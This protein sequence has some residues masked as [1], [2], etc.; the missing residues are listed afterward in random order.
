MPRN[1]KLL[2]AIVLS[3]CSLLAVRTYTQTQLPEGP[4]KAI[5][6]SV[7]TQCHDL[8]QAVSTGRTRDHWDVVVQK[9]IDYGA[10]LPTNQMSVVLD[11][12]A[13]S[14]PESVQA[15][16]AATGNRA[17]G[18]NAEFRVETVATGLAYPWSVAFLPNGDMLVTER[19]AARLRII[20]QGVLDPKPLKGLPPIY[21]GSPLSGL[22]DIVLHPRFAENGYLYLSYSKP[23]PDLTPGTPPL[24]ASIPASAKPGK[25]K[26]KTDALLRAR[27]DGKGLT[28]IREIFVDNNVMDDSIS[29]TS[30]LRLVFGSDGMLYMGTGAPTAPTA[31]GIYSKSKGGRAQDPMSHAGKVLRLRDD[32]TVPADNPFVGKAGYL[33]EIYTLGHRNILGLAVHPTTGELWEHE[34]GPQDG[35]ELNILKPGKNYGWPITGMGHD[36]T[37]D[38]I[39]G[40]DAIGP[41]A[42]RADARNYYLA[43]FEQPFLFWVPAV[44]P[45]GMAFYTGNRFP[46]WTGSLFIGVQKY[47]RLERHVFNDKGQPI[48]REYLLE[49]LKQRIRD[50]RQGPDGLVYLLTDENPGSLLR[51]EPNPVPD[52]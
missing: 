11:Y 31:S 30:A 26:T 21:T 49:D 43:N 4:G 7:C 25:G 41:E 48:R 17:A 16:A 33:P 13:K 45:S 28:D 37:G 36:Y 44:S 9:M 19:S 2:P 8:T 35:D 39:G 23:G 24:S 32:G 12:L 22:M 42:G 34:N 3:G 47:K 52:K 15:P 40:P 10:E 50:V 18:R 5:V 29:Q 14:F 51:L 20:Q 46:Q 27:W 38:F 1:F 6:Q